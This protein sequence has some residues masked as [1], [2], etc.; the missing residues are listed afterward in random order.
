MNF[1]PHGSHGRSKSSNGSGAGKRPAF[2]T[3]ASSESEDSGTERVFSAC[4]FEELSDSEHVQHK[5]D[6][7]KRPATPLKENL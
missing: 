3:A 6:K 1:E 7:T 4:L 2:S 5:C